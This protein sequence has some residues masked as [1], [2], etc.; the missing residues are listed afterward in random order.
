MDS[1]MGV[2]L[3]TAVE[4]RFGVNLPVMSL[5]EQ[6][7][8]EKLVERIVRALKDPTGAAEPETRTEQIERV[9]A[10]YA[11]EL[12]SREVGELVQAIDDAQANRQGRP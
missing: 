3:L 12:D 10:Q 5:S 6:P 2:E 8:I 7:S 1:L 11:A 9:A 4:A